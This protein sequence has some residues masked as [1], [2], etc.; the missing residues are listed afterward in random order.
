M[1]RPMHRYTHFKLA[2]IV[3]ASHQNFKCVAFTPP[4]RVA[5][6]DPLRFQHSA[7]RSPVVS[8]HIPSL[9]APPP[10]FSEERRKQQKEGKMCRS[11]IL[12]L[13]PANDVQEKEPIQHYIRPYLKQL[14]LLCRP[15]NFPIVALF[16]V[17][18]VQQAAHLWQTTSASSASPSLL[19]PLLKHPSILMVL[20]SLL[21]V[22][23]TSMITNDYYDAR[24]GVDSTS[25]DTDNENE[26]YH[27]LA[28]GEVPFSVTKT[29]DSYLYAILL[30]SSAFVPGVFSRLM[31]LGGAIIT[32]LYTVHLKPRTWI[33]NLSC[34]ALVAMSPVTSGLAA[35]HVLCDGAFLKSLGSGVGLGDAATISSFSIL[36]SPLSFLVVALFAG[37]MSREILMD[38]T[39]C[40]GDA[41]AGIETVPVRYGKGVASRVALGCS[42]ISAMSA[43][44]ASLIPWIPRLVEGGEPLRN[45]IA[46]PS[47][48]S[49][50]ILLTKSQARRALLSVAG[51]GMLLQRTY[52]V[53]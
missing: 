27:P 32:Y 20:L 15:V 41:Q 13:S 38:I 30:L 14:F 8:Q 29:F 5:D 45:L 2:V 25:N 51:S 36:K 28:Q 21:L 1:N 23:S 17:L 43:C 10:L 52:S 12:Y 40:E 48:S 50:T 46:I 18:G 9:Q 7:F 31:V 33:K 37:I 39:D 49:I 47:I 53:W 16:H 34:A 26:H 22:T 19:L 24:N 44:G 4:L 11:P 3:A 6:N 35:W 42:F